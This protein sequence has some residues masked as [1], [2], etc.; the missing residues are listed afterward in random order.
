MPIL[1]STQ[2]S[3]KIWRHSETEIDFKLTNQKGKEIYL[4]QKDSLAV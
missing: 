4:K 3:S 1:W 2:R